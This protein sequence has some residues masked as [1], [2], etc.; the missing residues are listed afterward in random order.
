[1]KLSCATS[2]FL[3]YSIF[4]AVPLIAQAG[5]QGIDLWGG[6]PHLYRRD[7]TPA[8][9]KRLHGLLQDHNLEAVSMMPAF[10]RYPHSLSS[11]NNAVRKDS[12]EYMRICLENAVSIGAKI[13]LI[14]PSRAL[15]GQ[16]QEDACQRLIDSIAEVC[17]DAAQYDLW[18]AIEP[19]NRF[20]T[21]LVTT[22]SD[23]L[24][25]I[26]R[27]NFPRLGVVMDTGH[28]NL[29]GESAAEAM[30]NLGSLLL[31]WHYNDNDGHHQ[32]NKVPGEGSFDFAGFIQTLRQAN[33]QG[34]LSLELGWDYSFAPVPG[35]TDGIGRMR[36]LL[37]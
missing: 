21:D 2:V 36:A 25:V 29:T 26:K 30:K 14:V 18:L 13:L 27:V 4:D 17:R 8:D 10:F 11:P 23:A 6:R 7:H 12:I 33:Y 19:A 5:C 37:G 32:Q 34:Y 20:V 16:T 28:I 1:M 31:Q 15:S 24:G 22:S 3:N 35:V 9:L